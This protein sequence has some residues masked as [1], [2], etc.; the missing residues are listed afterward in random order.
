M[1]GRN[2]FSG[3]KKVINIRDRNLYILRARI[4]N[5]GHRSP[6][7]WEWH[8]LYNVAKNRIAAH[9]VLPNRLQVFRDI[10]QHIDNI[11]LLLDY[12]V[13]KYPVLI[14]SALE[15]SERMVQPYIV[16]IEM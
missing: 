1:M 5:E 6:G 2:A 11:E 15:S 9:T 14:V 12:G 16:L 13:C 7:I 4:R 3:R 10:L 8:P